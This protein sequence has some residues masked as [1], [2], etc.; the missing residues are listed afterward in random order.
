V[1]SIEQ[2]PITGYDV[3]FNPKGDKLF[4]TSK[5]YSG[6]SIYE[7]DSREELTINDEPGI[8][9]GALINNASVLYKKETT[10]GF[11]GYDYIHKIPIVQNQDGISTSSEFDKAKVESKIQKVSWSEDLRKIQIH[12]RTGEIKEIQ[13]LGEKD[14]LNV[15]LSPDQKRLLFRVSGMGSFITNL[16]GEIFAKFENAEFPSWVDDHSI[17]YAEIIDDGYQY[18]KSAFIISTIDQ[19]NSICITK[20]MNVIGLFPK[21]SWDKKKVIFNTPEGDIYLMHFSD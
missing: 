3:Q 4:Y 5:N 18:L 12:Y 17:L 20:G 15:S 21:I 16:E 10:S 2:L 11:I 1:K 7:L 9:Y 8:G 14:Y 19:Q 6:L 13:P